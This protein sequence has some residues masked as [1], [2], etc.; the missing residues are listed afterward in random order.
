MLRGSCVTVGAFTGS[1]GTS[2]GMRVWSLPKVFHTCGKNCGK[3]TRSVIRFSLRAEFSRILHEAKP[4]KG[5]KIDVFADDICVNGRF[6][7]LDS[8]RSSTEHRFF[9]QK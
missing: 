2:C 9:E 7:G 5:R 6:I 4:R 3:T 8:R 1:P